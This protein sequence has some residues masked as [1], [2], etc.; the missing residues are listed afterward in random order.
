MNEEKPTGEIEPFPG[1]NR[2]LAV[3]ESQGGTHEHA[4]LTTAPAEETPPA[5]ALPWQTAAAQLAADIY[6]M[7]HGLTT[8]PTDAEGRARVQAI[9]QRL[10]PELKTGMGAV[11]AWAGVT[12]YLQAVREGLKHVVLRAEVHAPTKGR[13][14]ERVLVFADRLTVLSDLLQREPK[15]HSGAEAWWKEREDRLAVM[16]ELPV[17]IAKVERIFGAPPPAAA[18]CTV[19][20]KLDGIIEGLLGLAAKQKETMD[21]Y[22]QAL[23]AKVR[24]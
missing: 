19:V 12:L 8:A 14:N 17:I 6:C 7:A 21:R 16:E 20:E 23:K 10:E 2:T 1:M 4:Q 15:S 22:E 5:P 24:R 18:G 11:L 3:I 13:H 9:A